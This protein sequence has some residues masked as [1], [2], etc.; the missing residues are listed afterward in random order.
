M[1][2]VESITSDIIMFYT[3]KINSWWHIRIIQA[4]SKVFIVYEIIVI[5]LTSEGIKLNEVTHVML[6]IIE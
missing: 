4:L 5:F 2:N 6:K 3:Q 1:Y